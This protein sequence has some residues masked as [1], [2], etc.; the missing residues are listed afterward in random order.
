MIFEKRGLDA[1]KKVNAGPPGG[2]KRQLLADTDGRIWHAH[3]QAANEPD[4]VTALSLSA[5]ILCQNERLE[6]IYGNQAASAVRLQ[7]NFRS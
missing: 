6:K 5:E 4:G 1:N 7:R 3:V 2:R